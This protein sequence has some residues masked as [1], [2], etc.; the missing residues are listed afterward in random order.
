MV[1]TGL[2]HRDGSAPDV[3]ELQADLPEAEDG[4]RLPE[5]VRV[6][7]A[8]LKSLQDNGVDAYP[9]GQAPS[10]TI[11]EASTPTTRRR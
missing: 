2:L 8:K 5:Q 10:H 4:A 1:A 3:T 11:A 6:R 9:V 7:M